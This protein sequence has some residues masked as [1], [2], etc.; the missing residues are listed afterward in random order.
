MAVTL[1]RF[2][3]DFLV[4]RRAMG[5]GMGRDRLGGQVGRATAFFGFFSEK[6]DF[7]GAVK[8]P[9]LRV[10]WPWVLDEAPELGR[11]LRTKIRKPGALR[12]T[13][14]FF[15]SGWQTLSM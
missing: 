11:P 10:R 9:G 14:G 1:N 7:Q 13:R 4:F 12:G 5:L 15:S 3:T 2:A 8:S 6:L